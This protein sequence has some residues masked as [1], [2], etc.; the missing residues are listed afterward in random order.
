MQNWRFQLQKYKERQISCL[1]RRECY[2]CTEIL[3]T[4]PESQSPHSGF[5]LVKTSE[6]AEQALLN[7]HCHRPYDP[8]IQRIASTA[9]KWPNQL[10]MILLRYCL[11]A[12]AYFNCVPNKRPFPAGRTEGQSYRHLLFNHRGSF[13]IL[14]LSITDLTMTR[15][16]TI[17]WIFQRMRFI[18]LQL[19]RK[20]RSA[21]FAKNRNLL[22]LRR[23][24]NITYLPFM[25]APALHATPN[26]TSQFSGH[27]ARPGFR[28]ANR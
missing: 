2:Y 24:R 25:I 15:S 23:E 28:Y 13:R 21:C 19:L 10:R 22:H 26:H 3:N 14:G 27:R 5:S 9:H 7:L 6:R 16:S 1:N 11:S 8:K 18:K 20:I 12:Q 17:V 4:D